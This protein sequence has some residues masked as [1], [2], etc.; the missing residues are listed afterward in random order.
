MSTYL[1][2]NWMETI[3]KTILKNLI[4]NEDYTRKVLPF[5]KKDYFDSVHEKVIFEES[6]RF[7][8]EY[9]SVPQ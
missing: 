3:E 6:E 4:L 5:I 1:H 2:Y 9:K 7:I 8:S